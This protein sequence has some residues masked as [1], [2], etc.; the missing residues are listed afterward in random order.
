MSAL[1]HMD[2]SQS[3]H[4]CVD[5]S[6]TRVLPGSM[7]IPSFPAAALG[8]SDEAL[9]VSARF[10]QAGHANSGILMIVCG[11]LSRAWDQPFL[12]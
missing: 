1:G 2:V 12:I 10:G 4:C 3:S 6:H 7:P 9:N 11:A 5:L 8:V